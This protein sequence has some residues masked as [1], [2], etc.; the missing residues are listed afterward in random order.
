MGRSTLKKKKLNRDGYK[1]YLTSIYPEPPVLIILGGRNT[2][3][4][5]PRLRKWLLEPTL[6]ALYSFISGNSI[7]GRR[8]VLMVCL[9]FPLIIFIFLCKYAQNE[10]QDTQAPIISSDIEWSYSW[11]FT[12]PRA[13][14]TLYIKYVPPTEVFRFWR[15]GGCILVRFRKRE[16]GKDTGLF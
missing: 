12:E 8:R 9:P 3:N 7:S 10:R 6:G 1:C 5:Q 13:N 14:G 2:T 16:R 11:K 4:E 15:L